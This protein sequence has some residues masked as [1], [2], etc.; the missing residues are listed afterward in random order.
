MG[1]VIS[2]IFGKLIP[3]FGRAS[4]K[5]L[6]SAVGQKAK[7]AAKK[8]LKKLGSA[9]LQTAAN[10]ATKAIAG[11]S[12]EE[13]KSGVSKDIASARKEIAKTLQSEIKS[14]EKGDKKKKGSVLAARPSAGSKVARRKKAVKSLLD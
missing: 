14:R 11:E 9:A 7:R 5:V 3:F 12:K 2:R 8:S 4:S 6:K 13:I 10:A 1:A